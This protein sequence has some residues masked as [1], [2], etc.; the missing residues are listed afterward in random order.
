MI[1][2]R[3]IEKDRVAQPAPVQEPVADS[4]VFVAVCNYRRKTPDGKKD[5]TPH[6]DGVSRLHSIIGVSR[7]KEGAGRMAKNAE[8]A[9]RDTFLAYRTLGRDPMYVWEV[10][11]RAIEAA[12]GITEQKGGAA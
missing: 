6:H 9:Y 12:H 7:T 2:A 4:L 3:A 11:E 1:V 5:R 8:D 10:E